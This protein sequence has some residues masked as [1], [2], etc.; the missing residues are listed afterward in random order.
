[1]V[2]QLIDSHYIGTH[3]ESSEIR[4]QIHMTKK[5]TIYEGSSYTLKLGLGLGFVYDA[6]SRLEFAN[7]KQRT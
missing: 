3:S 4:T 5:Y 2:L 6:R 7:I 1:M